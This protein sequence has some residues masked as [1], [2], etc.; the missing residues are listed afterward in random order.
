MTTTTDDAYAYAA[1]PAAAAAAPAGYD[2]LV[3]DLA[4]DGYA[5][6]AV[7]TVDA[8]VRPHALA[9]RAGRDPS[10]SRPARANAVA[11]LCTRPG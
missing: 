10:G 2:P 4:P 11:Q 6:K 1:S 5:L 9:H 8:E 3:S 7:A